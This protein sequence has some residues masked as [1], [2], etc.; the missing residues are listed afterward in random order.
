MVGDGDTGAVED[1]RETTNVAHFLPV[2]T[3][4]CLALSPEP[5]SKFELKSRSNK[6]LEARF[7]TPDP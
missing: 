2:L 6:S 5:S 4:P 7:E 3:P 1:A